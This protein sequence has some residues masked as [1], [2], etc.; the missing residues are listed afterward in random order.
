MGKNN[1][2]G[3]APY[4]D[5]LSLLEGNTCVLYRALADRA[6]N[7]KAKTLLLTL[8]ADSQKHANQLKT[9][10]A[11]LGQAKAKAKPGDTQTLE[12]VFKVT[13]AIFK[14]IIAQ[15]ETTPQ[16]LSAL[17]AKLSLLEETLAEKYLFVQAKTAPLL[18]RDSNFLGLSLDGFGSMFEGLISDGKLHLK[19]LGM[20]AGFALVEADLQLESLV[21]SVELPVAM[22]TQ[23]R[24]R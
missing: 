8:A 4:F 11:Q 22:S 18:K 7:P 10:A 20:L 14:D 21:V 16:E 23:S 15:E 5:C 17:A 19:Q 12:A 24:H 3:I 1:R 9:V 2:L 13:F 6:K